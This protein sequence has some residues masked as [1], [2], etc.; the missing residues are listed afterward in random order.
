[1]A[2]VANV[3]INVNANSAV[4]QLNNLDKAANQLQK[5]TTTLQS[6]FAGLGQA[7]AAIGLTTLVKSFATA[8]I[9]AERTAKRIEN[10]SKSSQ[11]VS[12]IQN[13]AATA[14]KEFGLGNLTAS[15]GIADLYARL[16]PTGI[17]LESIQDIFIGTNKAALNMGLTGQQLSNV[18]LQLS[19]ALGSGVLQG[20]EFRSVAE[21]LP[22]VMDAVAKALGVSRGE[23]KKLSSEGKVTTDV[24]VKA[25]QEL[26][27]INTIK[28]DAYREFSAATENLS[29]AIG[30]KLLPALTPLVKA[31]T[32]L[33]HAFSA[34]PG[35]VQTAIVGIAGLAAGIGILTPIISGISAALGALAGFFGSTGAAAGVFATA[36]TGVTAILTALKIG[37]VAI[38]GVLTGL[39]AKALAGAAAL[40]S[41]PVGIAALL[42]AA[43]AAAYLFRDRIANTF[44]SFKEIVASA[45]NGF[46]QNFLQPLTRGIG[47]LLNSFS[48]FATET[49][50]IF[51]GLF[52][53]IL[54][55]V[56]NFANL[57]INAIQDTMNFGI[58]GLNI[59]VKGLNKILNSLGTGLT[60][61]LIPEVKLPKFAKGGYVTSPTTAMIGEG[62]QPEY[63]IPA[64]AMSEAMA[65]YGAGMRGAS[66]IP[67]S[68]NPQ[69]NISTGPVMQ[70]NGTNYVSQNDLVSATQA[71]ARQGA[72]MALNQ[73]ERD[74]ATRRRVGVMR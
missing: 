38:A 29:V 17:S 16:S 72:N 7:I 65:R 18:M 70:M 13:I 46:R 64:N 34:L 4:T 11:D 15:Q 14:A 26:A 32:A 55:G 43:G 1:M 12:R 3:E 44:N 40:F 5:R 66:V 2:A 56:S 48:Q 8:G 36:I 52:Q 58:K 51:E 68:I 24:L 59:V 54:A 73:L 61:E 33:I 19:Q 41:G 69:V 63:V 31:L 67:N 37:V 49:K 74:P 23:L 30:T 57:F 6:A 53:S 21:A 35:P 39:L 71:A 27:K 62:G 9:E 22:P 42:I 25:F 20:D 47:L 10:L 50:R 60:F 45:F 28:P